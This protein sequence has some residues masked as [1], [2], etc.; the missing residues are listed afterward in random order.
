MKRFQF[1]TF[2]ARI[3]SI[4]IESLKSVGGYTG[5]GP[6]KSSSWFELSLKEWQELNCTAPF[7]AFCKQLRSFVGPLP[8][9]LLYKQ[10]ISN[11]LI[12]YLIDTKVDL[13]WKPVSNI[14]AMLAKDLDEEFYPHFLPLFD[15]LIHVLI[16][17]QEPDVIEAAFTSVLFIFKTQATSVL[18]D[19]PVIYPHFLSLISKRAFLTKFAAQVVSYLLR[20]SDDIT[21]LL[22]VMLASLDQDDHF[23]P[24]VSDI[25]CQTVHD[26]RTGKLR[27]CTKP[28]I[29][30]IYS[31][32][33][34]LNLLCPSLLL[35][36]KHPN[37]SMEDINGS[38]C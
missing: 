4:S 30:A 1:E 23:L 12:Q 2:S 21:P 34:L 15:A 24:F 6:D 22:K 10:D 19:F 20:R 18:K 27:A 32:P 26:E 9:I 5:S 37:S 28:L 25:I 11:L 7:R 13:A 33:K 31:H 8:L 35:E 36:V 29:V 16:T 17:S 14:V 3:D 38:F